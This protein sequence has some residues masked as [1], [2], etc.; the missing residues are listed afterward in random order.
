MRIPR[1]H[2][3]NRA[4]LVLM[5]ALLPFLACDAVHLGPALAGAG[6]E[7]GHA[8]ALAAHDG[9]GH[10]SHDCERGIVAEP[11]HRVVP[12]VALAAA[13]ALPPAVQAPGSVSQP[14]RSW[15]PDPIPPPAHTL[16]HQHVLIRI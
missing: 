12:A 2:T 4:S 6:A 1:R 8:A 3:L 9:H 13:L 16:I 11:A 7:A 5:L 15:A 14:S 10:E